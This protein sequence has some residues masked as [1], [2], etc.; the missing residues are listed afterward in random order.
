MTVV[1]IVA[2]TMS[3]ALH[4]RTVLTGLAASALP[5]GLVQ[6]AAPRIRFGAAVMKENFNDDARYRAAIVEHCDIITPMNDLKW[7]ALRPERDKFSFEDAD[8]IIAFAQ[9]TRKEIRGHALCWYNA[10][11][12][13]AQKL[14]T[15]AEAER[16]LRQ[17]IETVVA[18]YKGV[19]SSWDV[20]NEAIAHDPAP[21][22]PWRD[23]I[24]H[25]LLGQEHIDIAFQTAARTDPAV[26]LVYNDYDYE[27]VGPRFEAR[28]KI[29]IDMIRRLQAKKIPI[30]GVGIQAHLYAERAIDEEGI[31]SFGADLKALGV[32]MLVTELDVIDWRLPADIKQRDV[33]AARHVETFLNAASAAQPGLPV[34]TWGMTDKYS[35]VGETFP[36][37]DKLAARPL[38]LDDAYRAKPMMDVIQRLRRG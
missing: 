15:R 14:R 16:E 25:R 36:R 37:T 21:S 33:A 23:T 38:P 3:H 32:K 12:A 29:T 28:R 19:I 30:H 26:E 18:R 5:A 4:R 27:N 1:G 34:I 31:A 22:R 8:R 6:A 24:W 20:V 35:W 7:E 9:K 2:K 11:P 10:M 17:H 13:W